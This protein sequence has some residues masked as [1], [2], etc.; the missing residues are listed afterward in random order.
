MSEGLHEKR[1]RAYMEM[2]EMSEAFRKLEGLILNWEDR[3]SNVE[4]YCQS[5]HR[6]FA[7]D[8]HDRPRIDPDFQ[9]DRIRVLE[10]QVKHL[11]EKIKEVLCQR[12]TVIKIETSSSES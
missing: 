4:N 12:T 9:E 7:K 3:V 11:N 8:I 5:L 1:I 6:T 10:L 2:D